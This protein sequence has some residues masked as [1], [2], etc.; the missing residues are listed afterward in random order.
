MRSRSTRRQRVFIW[1]ITFE[2]YDQFKELVNRL[3]DV[4]EDTEEGWEIQE[5]IRSLPGFPKDAPFPGDAK[6]IFEK[7]FSR[8]T[9]HSKPLIH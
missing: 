7:Q 4:G 1:P 6:I 2:V 5:E 8:A 3:M 9:S